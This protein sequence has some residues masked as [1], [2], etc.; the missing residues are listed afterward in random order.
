MKPN[1]CSPSCPSCVGKR[2][3]PLLIFKMDSRFASLHLGSRQ[4]YTKRPGLILFTVWLYSH[5]PDLT[6]TLQSDP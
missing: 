3:S 5:K 6:D 4:H 2:I 1:N